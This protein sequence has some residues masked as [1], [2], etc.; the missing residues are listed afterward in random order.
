MIEVVITCNDWL[1][2]GKELSSNISSLACKNGVSEGRSSSDEGKG[3]GTVSSIVVVL[4][5]GE[6]IV[7]NVSID[8]E[9]IGMRRDSMVDETSL[10]MNAS[11]EATLGT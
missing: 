9:V 7:T 1:G 2:R 11:I 5:E 8:S 6:M 4:G 3:S 10:F